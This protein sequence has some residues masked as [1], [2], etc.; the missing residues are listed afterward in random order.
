[1][2]VSSLRLSKSCWQRRPADNRHHRVVRQLILL[3]R[4]RVRPITAL[5]PLFWELRL[6]QKKA[7]MLYYVYV[8]RGRRHLKRG[9]SGAAVHRTRERR[10]RKLSAR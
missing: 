3:G 9:K 10:H 8:A 4:A 6:R 2:I 5:S 1:M 7:V